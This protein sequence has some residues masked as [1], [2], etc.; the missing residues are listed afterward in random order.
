MALMAKS[1]FEQRLADLSENVGHGPLKGQML[2][3]QPYAAV[4]EVEESYAHPQGGQA[5]YTETAL[6][7]NQSAIYEDVADGFLHGGAVDGMASGMEKVSE[8]IEKLAPVDTS[9]LR[10]SGNPRVM[11]DGTV[12][13]DRPPIAPREEE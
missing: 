9:R 3:N 2:V 12:V 4:Q 6:R 5:H 1:T 10:H 7:S 13:Y 11:S 8:S